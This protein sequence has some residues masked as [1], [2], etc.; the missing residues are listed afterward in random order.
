MTRKLLPLAL[1]VAGL[2]VSP[3]YG[4][5]ADHNP[6]A[7]TDPAGDSNGAPDITRVTVANSLDGLLLFV[8]QVGNR[9]A[10]VANDRVSLLI[11]SDQNAQT[12][13][14]TG[15]IDFIIRIDGTAQQI[16][17][18]RWNGTA[19][20]FAAVT[21][22]RGGWGPG[23]VVGINR[24]ELGNTTGFDFLVL[25]SLADG[26]ENQVDFAPESEDGRY[27]VS[28]PHI[29]SITP[30][31]PPVTPTAGRTLRLNGVQL[32]FETEETAAAA[33]FSCR[34][35]L[36]GKRLRGTGP[37]GCTFKLPKTAK[38]KQLVITVTATPA[39]GRAQTFP[40]YRFRVR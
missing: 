36:A 29:A 39:G 19:F 4:R 28:A 22:L 13:A 8:I 33:S 7:M 3:A 32:T 26:A 11:D 30:R 5:V 25:T 17:L 37:G 10:I 31:F 24:A 15:G 2:A 6:L 20:E 21:S 38:R 1:L 9:D 18:A 34:A 35:T 14:Q 16:V 40:A 27:T 12:G 23:Y